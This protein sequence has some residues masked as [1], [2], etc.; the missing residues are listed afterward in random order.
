VHS[1]D[2]GFESLSR[3]PSSLDTYWRVAAFRNYADYAD[4]S[5]HV[6]TPGGSMTGGGFLQVVG[7]PALLGPID[8]PDLA[9]PKTA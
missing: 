8:L 9:R 4:D 3:A 6:A 1:I 2:I 7:A 5:S